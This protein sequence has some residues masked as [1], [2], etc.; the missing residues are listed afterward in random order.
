MQTRMQTRMQTYIKIPM[1]IFINLCNIYGIYLLW[2][3]LHYTSSHLYIYYCTPGSLIGF[4]SSPIIAPLPHCQAFR[5][6]IYNGGN[7][8]IN[9]WIIVG[10]WITKYLVII[11]IKSAST[12]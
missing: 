5:W 9:M 11:T 3:L 12:N 7:S 8:I 4:L 2:I 1:Q 10:L 6:I